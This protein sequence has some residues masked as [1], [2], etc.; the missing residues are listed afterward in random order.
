MGPGKLSFSAMI[1]LVFFYAFHA[2]D[3]VRINM[4]ILLQVYILTALAR[5]TPKDAK[6]A[7][8]IVDRV[9]PRLNHANSAGIS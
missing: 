6:E 7:E 1:A 4:L 9:A 3:R 2:I 5:Y 8:A